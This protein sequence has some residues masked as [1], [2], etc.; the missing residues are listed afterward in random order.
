MLQLWLPRLWN[1]ASSI[2]GAAGALGGRWQWNRADGIWEVCGGWL[3]TLLSRQGWAGAI[4][5]GEV[6]L[7]ADCHLVA[8][9]HDHEMVHVKQGR[10]WGPLFLPA[11]VLESAYQWLCTGDGYRRNRFEIAAYAATEPEKPKQE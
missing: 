11:Y 9:L 8:A 5:L 3:I 2:I 1:G 7:Y 6:V 4:T 10:L